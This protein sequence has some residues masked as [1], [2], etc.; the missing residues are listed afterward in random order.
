[1]LAGAQ[2]DHG[3]RYEAVLRAAA[4]T[5]ALG[6]RAARAGALDLAAPAD[7]YEARSTVRDGARAV[8]DKWREVSS[9]A[10]GGAR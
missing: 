2:I 10:R 3:E 1:M 4:M 6:A 7:Q 9:A 5:A 8:L